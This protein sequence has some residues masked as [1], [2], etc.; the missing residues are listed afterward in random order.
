MNFARA[1]LLVCVLFSGFARA[2][3]WKRWPA[4]AG[5]YGTTISIPPGFA[6][7]K[8]RPALQVKPGKDAP[9][10]LS[11]RFRSK[12]GKVVFSVIVYYV[13]GLTEN[14]D[15]RRIKMSLES[16]E[17][18]GGQSSKRKKE[19]SEVGPYFVY[20]EESTVSGAGYTRYR[21]NEFSTSSLPGAASVFWEFQVAD[22][23]ARKHYAPLWKRFKDTLEVE[24]D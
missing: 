2:E 12:D 10:L 23:A 3:D 6:V 4:D 14:A 15:G 11:G 13:R 21:L 17:K 18:Q 16:G 22:E 5:E 20:D 1:L 8:W 7:V 24:G 9:L 19:M